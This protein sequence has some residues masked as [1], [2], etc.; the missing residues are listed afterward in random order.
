MHESIQEPSNRLLVY[1]IAR[2]GASEAPALDSLP[3]T[4]KAPWGGG[5]CFT[6]A[7]SLISA[8]LC[9]C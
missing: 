5:C 7:F 1:I 6:N 2:E 3:Q 9:S 8:T 4:R